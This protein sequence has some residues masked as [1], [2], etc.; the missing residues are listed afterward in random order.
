EGGVGQRVVHHDVDAEGAGRRGAGIVDV[1][2]VFADR[3]LAGQGQRPV[4]AVHVD[5]VAVFAGLE[6]ADRL[7]RRLA[8]GLAH[9]A[10]APGARGEVSLRGP[11]SRSRLAIPNSSIISTRRRLPSSLQAASA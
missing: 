6:V 3:H 4:V 11:R 10:A 8:R 9:G 2:A 7:Q 5:A 1:Y